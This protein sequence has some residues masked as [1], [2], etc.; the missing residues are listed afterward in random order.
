MD[1]KERIANLLNTYRQEIGVKSPK[2]LA[3]WQ[4]NRSVMPA[5]T[6]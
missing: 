1:D 3:I 2:S 5:G 6:A 4:E